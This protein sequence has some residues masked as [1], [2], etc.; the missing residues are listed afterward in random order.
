MVNLYKYVGR[1]VNGVK[2]GETTNGKIYKEIKKYPHELFPEQGG[3]SFSI[4]Y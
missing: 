2:I 1:R 4:F 3:D